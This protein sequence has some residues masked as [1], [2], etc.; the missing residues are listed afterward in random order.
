MQLSPAPAEYSYALQVASAIRG[1]PLTD[2]GRTM[3]VHMRQTSSTV[4]VINNYHRILCVRHHYNELFAFNLSSRK[5]VLITSTNLTG[6]F[7]YKLRN[8]IACLVWIIVNYPLQISFSPMSQVFARSIGNPVHWFK[9]V[10][11]F[12]VAEPDVWT[13]GNWFLIFATSMLKWEAATQQCLWAPS[14]VFDEEFIQCSPRFSLQL[15]LWK[16]ESNVAS[17]MRM[18]GLA[19]P[20][21]FSSSVTALLPAL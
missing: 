5:L 20:L 10:I 17:W 16:C 8:L 14:M 13:Q 19:K 6:A 11:W 12:E 7:E 4:Y 18:P 9:T 21:V 1:A 15:K 3:S 2:I